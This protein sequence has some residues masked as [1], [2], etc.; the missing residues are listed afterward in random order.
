VPTR[1]PAV[2]AD[3]AKVS[4]PLVRRRRAAV[5]TAPGA[6]AGVAVVIGAPPPL[7]PPRAA[8]SVT[9]S[10]P[11]VPASRK[12]V[13]GDDDDA[14]DDAN[15]G[16]VAPRGLAPPAL[17]AKAAAAAARA[18]RSGGC[19]SRPSAAIGDGAC[20]PAAWGRRADKATT[21]AP[22]VATPLASAKLQRQQ[23]PWLARNTGQRCPEKSMWLARAC[24]GAGARATLRHDGHEP[25]R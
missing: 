5:R 16:A 7:A 13:R 1:V 24:D 21:T 11:P 8:S 23:Q 12:H 19:K 9:L 10:P 15:D 14:D 4:L 3:V 20:V 25:R 22:R 6:S 17:A 18:V 2:D